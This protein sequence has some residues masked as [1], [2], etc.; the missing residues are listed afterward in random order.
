VCVCVCVCETWSSIFREGHGLKISEKKSPEKNIWTQETR[1]AWW[2]KK[3]SKIRIFTKCSLDKI[4]LRV[5][6][7]NKTG[8]GLDLFHLIHPHNS[9]LQ[10]IQRCR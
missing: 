9:K 5:G 3:N 7:T 6:V 10:A 4:L 1:S 8:F 2:M